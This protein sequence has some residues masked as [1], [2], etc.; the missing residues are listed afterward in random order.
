MR[1]LG[2]VLTLAVAAFGCYSSS[3]VGA[4]GAGGAGGMAG[5]G[6]TGPAT[7][8]CVN[9]GDLS[10]VCSEDNGIQRTLTACGYCSFIGWGCPDACDGSP[11]PP[12]TG[13]SA[14]AA[15]TIGAPA[16][17]P[18]ISLACL[19]CY[20]EVSTCG[21]VNCSAPCNDDGAA[22]LCLDCVFE[23]CDA[24]F[25]ACAGFSA[26]SSKTPGGPPTCETQAAC[27][28]GGGAGGDGGAGGGGGVGGTGGAGGNG[29]GGVG[30][31]RATRGI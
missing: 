12:M 9:G 1:P 8:A 14:C 20:I 30:G 26:G 18:G 3:A 29:S 6:G 19:D 17:D 5:A 10:F 25:T 16:C 27:R 23:H 24:D 21:T 2:L 31:A 22:C 7:G 11:V 13:A 28:G 4:A 15:A